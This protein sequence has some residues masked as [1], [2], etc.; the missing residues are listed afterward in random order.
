MKNWMSK[1]LA[2]HRDAEGDRMLNE[3]LRDL[4]V[5]DPIAEAAAASSVPASDFERKSV[6]PS[7][8]E[9]PAESNVVAAHDLSIFPAVALCGSP[10]GPDPLRGLADLCREIQVHKDYPRVRA[11]YC[12]L[13]IQLNELGRLAPAYRPLIKTGAG[14]KSAMNMV[15][16]RDQVVIDLHWCYARQMAI[17]ASDSAH[18]ALFELSAE[19]PFDLAW[20]ISGKK[21]RGGYRAAE[22]LCLTTFQQCQLLKL[23]GPEVAERAAALEI[24]WKESGGK[25]VSK[26]AAVKKQIGQWAERDKRIVSQRGCYEQLWLARELLG[27]SCSSAQVAELHAL[28]VGGDVQDRATIRDK[29]KSL[30]KQ[31]KGL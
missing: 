16:H 28:M 17:S 14:W 31:L 2:A 1:D 27:P 20:A 26:I 12:S 11:D 29:L 30:D 4:S 22:A 9:V 3:L 15:L 5:D 7:A 10:S 19:F 18:Q 13:S 24:G 25:S 8:A 23:R 21:W 6:T